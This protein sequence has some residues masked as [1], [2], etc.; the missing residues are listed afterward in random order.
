MQV[1]SREILFIRK[2]AP[3]GFIRTVANNVGL[4]YQQVRTELYS[5]KENYS[6]VVVLESRRLLE[7]M[8]GLVYNAN[9]IHA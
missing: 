7:A 8:T 9:E 4:D 5:L 6:D 1:D 3:K 2:N